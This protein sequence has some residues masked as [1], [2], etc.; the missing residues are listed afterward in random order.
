MNRARLEPRDSESVIGGAPLCLG[1]SGLAGLLGVSLRSVRRLD[2][3]GKLPEALK[4]GGSKR[5]FRPEVE[6]WLRA[7]APSRRQWTSMRRGET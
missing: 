2:D 5:W 6:E 3:S 1:A 4:I 7:G